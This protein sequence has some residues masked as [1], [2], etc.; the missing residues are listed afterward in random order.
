MKTLALLL[1]D[2]E[3][4]RLV[5]ELMNNRQIRV[6]IID[7]KDINPHSPLD[8]KPPVLFVDGETYR[9]VREIKDVINR[10]FYL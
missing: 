7:I 10:N 1:D 6:T 4:S 5:K 9:G 3:P 8:Y 2:S